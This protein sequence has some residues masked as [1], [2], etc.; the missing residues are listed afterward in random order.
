LKKK[1]R[2]NAAVKKS[3]ID[4]KDMTEVAANM[5]KKVAN[6]TQ[7]LNTLAKS[8]ANNKIINEIANITNTLNTDQI[9]DIKIENESKYPAD[10][11]P[12]NV[13]NSIY[14]YVTPTDQYLDVK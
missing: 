5:I 13:A 4:L 7:T 6:P 11:N 14:Q 9:D 2:T 10:Y 1:F 3:D 8:P 12:S